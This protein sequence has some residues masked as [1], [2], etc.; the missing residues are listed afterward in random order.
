[1]QF[2]GDVA[3][4]TGATLGIGRATALAFAREGARVIVHGRSPER[5]AA[6]VESICNEGGAATAF[7]CDL[8]EIGAAERL[9]AF[10]LDT[11]GA[12]DI[13]VNN[14][15]FNVAGSVIEL[16]EADW[17]RSMAVMLKAAFLTC[18]YALPS[19]LA[20]GRGSII[21]VSSVHG[22]LGFPRH[23]AYDTAKAGLINLTR[24]LAVEFGPQGIRANAVCPGSIFISERDR[25]ISEAEERQ[26]AFLYPMRR[27]GQPEEVARVITFLASEAASFVTG[28]SI[29]VDGGLTAQLPDYSFLEQHNRDFPPP[30]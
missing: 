22:A 24:Q 16:A 18:K 13:L 17:D 20:R 26:R 2:E 12:I 25:P 27:F 29:A 23:P 21:N 19:M 14:A 1:M 10:A 4:V 11:Y 3:I 6:V 5:S 7:R 28:Q 8:A 30:G 9:V 15:R